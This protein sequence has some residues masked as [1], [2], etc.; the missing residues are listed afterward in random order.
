[1]LDVADIAVQIRSPSH[2]FPKLNRQPIV[3]KTQQIGPKGWAETIQD[4]LSNQLL[5]TTER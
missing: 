3:I 5:S 4:L 2:K 1:M